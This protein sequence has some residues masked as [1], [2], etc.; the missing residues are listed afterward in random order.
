MK[1]RL[2]EAPKY[3]FFDDDERSDASKPKLVLEKVEMTCEEMTESPAKSKHTPPPSKM[4]D[5]KAEPAYLSPSM[6]VT[7][8]LK[9][10]TYTPDPD[11]FIVTGLVPTSNKKAPRPCT[12]IES[13][14]HYEITGQSETEFSVDLKCSEQ[15]RTETMDLDDT[16]LIRHINESTVSEDIKTERMDEY[17]PDNT[18]WPNDTAMNNAKHARVFSRNYQM[19]AQA[20]NMS[21]SNNMQ[22]DMNAP[23][24][25]RNSPMI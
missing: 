11:E 3:N 13:K 10:S 6:D 1:K 22:I 9:D 14:Q 21:L 24:F 25:E 19:G 8:P 12:P 15:L 5:K 17:T 16:R 2:N 4:K 23:T 18:N 20:R 7:L